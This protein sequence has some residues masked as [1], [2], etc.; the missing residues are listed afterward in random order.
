[1]ASQ[2]RDAAWPLLVPD[3][4]FVR[5]ECKCLNVAKLPVLYSK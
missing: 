4:A 3:R 5:L 1:M 2:E